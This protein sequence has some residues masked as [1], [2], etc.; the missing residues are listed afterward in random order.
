MLK[1]RLAK[2]PVSEL[3]VADKERLEDI[4]LKR[5]DLIARLA[6]KIAPKIRKIEQDRLDRS[7]MNEDAGPKGQSS[8]SEDKEE[9]IEIGP[10][11]KEVLRKH[12]PEAIFDDGG[13]QDPDYQTQ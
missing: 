13:V 10:D 12:S 9:F 5:K 3:S 11:G 7:R 6:N 2:K 1:E 8:D 4:L